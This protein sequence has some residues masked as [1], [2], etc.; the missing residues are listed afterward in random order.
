M[1]AAAACAGF[2][3][4]LNWRDVPSEAARKLRV[5]LLD[6]IAVML[7]GAA[8]PQ[9][10][11]LR[12]C[13]GET[14]PTSCTVVGL[15][16]RARPADAALLNAF[17]GRRH[18]F[19]DTLEAGPIHPGSVVWAAS[20][21]AG[22]A[23]DAPLARV[24][25]A[26]LCGYE[27]AVRLA[28]SLGAGHYDAGFHGTGTC[29][30]PA[31]ELAAAIAGGL[32]ATASAH[33][34][35]LAAAAA[36]GTRQ[37]QLDGSI[38]HSALNGARAAAAGVQSA[39]YAAA[40]LDGPRRQ[41]DGRW[42]LLGL[43]ATATGE[44]GAFDLLGQ[45]WRFHRV[46]LKP[47]PTCR[48]THGPVDV[49]NSLRDEHG[50]G[51]ENV[52]AIELS[53][54]RQSASVSDRPTWRDREEAILSHQ[55]AL[56]ATLLQGPPTFDALDRLAADA[57]VRALAASITVSCDP[58]LEGRRADEWPHVLRVR[59]RDG[60]ELSR[61]SLVPPG[62][63]PGDHARSA[64]HDK[65]ERLIGQHLGAE[66]FAAIEAVL[67]DPPRHGVRDLT[68]LLGPRSLGRGV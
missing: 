41:L 39:C 10:A 15:G 16:E 22:E 54:F 56:A 68:M 61:T 66:R 42:G 8:S 9:A 6:T 2:A 27:L 65:A 53:T 7:A 30:A 31:A 20:L 48:F 40:G 18:T 63:L 64:I 37:Y 3:A 12:E 24:L 34:I 45:T 28:D 50:L 23:A 55:F 57:T 21:A 60:T 52:A 11:A 19:D 59:L 13:H 43:F 14:G 36:A 46:G 32:D 5:H 67:A 51:T 49:L 47:Y 1:N 4:A 58:A 35:A 29:N 26:A 44:T 17:A 33:A 38:V 25:T 62:S